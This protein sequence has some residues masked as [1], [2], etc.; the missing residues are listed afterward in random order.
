LKAISQDLLTHDV[1]EPADKPLAIPDPALV[2]PQITRR[3][4]HIPEIDHI[5][6]SLSSKL[7]SRL[8]Y[9]IAQPQSVHHSEGKPYSELLNAL[10]REDFTPAMPLLGSDNV[11]MT[12]PEWTALVEACVR[13]L[14]IKY[15]HTNGLQLQE[16][17]ADGTFTA[18]RLMKVC[19]YLNGSHYSQPHL[20][21]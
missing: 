16:H 6:L 19:S 8:S 2:L 9:A 13:L 10:Q 4:V 7:K 21:T 18:L 5:P 15:H 14:L 12:L 17:D 1:P 20:E 3:I 11:V